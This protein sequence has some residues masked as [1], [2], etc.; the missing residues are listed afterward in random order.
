MRLFRNS[1]SHPSEEPPPLNGHG[2]DGRVS[3]LG[4][5]TSGQFSIREHKVTKP[6]RLRLLANPWGNARPRPPPGWTSASSLGRR[7]RDDAFGPENRQ[8]RRRPGET[9]RIDNSSSDL[10]VSAI[11]PTLLS[12]SVLGDELFQGSGH[13]EMKPP[14]RCADGAMLMVDRAP[15]TMDDAEENKEN[16]PQALDFSH[17]SLSIFRPGSWGPSFGGLADRLGKVYRG[18]RRSRTLRTRLNRVSF[19]RSHPPPAVQD[20]KQEAGDEGTST[21]LNSS[22]GGR[23]WE[24]VREM[25][26]ERDRSAE[27]LIVARLQKLRRLRSEMVEALKG[28]REARLDLISSAQSALGSSSGVADMPRLR[29]IFSGDAS[30]AAHFKDDNDFRRLLRQ[31]KNLEALL[32]GIRKA[33]AAGDFNKLRDLMHPPSRSVDLLELLKAQVEVTKA[34]EALRINADQAAREA[35]ED[36]RRRRQ[37]EVR[38]QEAARL[39]QERAAAEAEQNRRAV[40]EKQRAEEEKQRAEEARREALLRPKPHVVE[41]NTLK[42]NA[43]TQKAIAEEVMNSKDPGVKKIRILFKKVYQGSINQ[44]SLDPAK[45]GDVV[46]K[47]G[48]SCL[49]PLEQAA[50]DGWGP[51]G[52]AFLFYN[53]SERLISQAEMSQF[54]ADNYGMAFPVACVSVDLMMLRPGLAKLFW[55]MFYSKCPSAIPVMPFDTEGKTDQ[56]ILAAFGKSPDESMEDYIRRTKGLIVF[57]GAIMQTPVGVDGGGAEHPMPLAQGWRWL[58]RFMNA[59]AIYREKGAPLP[60][61]TGPVLEGFLMVA[62]YELQRRYGSAME[63]IVRAIKK[64]ILPILLPKSNVSHLLDPLIHECERNHWR[65]FKPKGRESTLFESYRAWGET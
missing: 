40:E 6:G 26:A 38:L 50:R 32:E 54:D 53:L 29:E 58:S 28:A 62:G 22:V 9:G 55:G 12:G 51:K 52:E 60:P 44:L 61:A 8:S 19:L 48:N 36:H 59:L 64:D 5:E 16:G 57:M 35:E 31:Y 41:A 11:A 49:L 15:H 63:K 17:A 24:K 10:L 27:Q 30:L 25:E 56:E 45:V 42:E 3:T 46:E 1:S 2:A 14:G 43:Q 23:M 47:I 7:D 37:E 33:H 39:A 65:F 18:K 4:R 34:A 21:A 13:S 20:E